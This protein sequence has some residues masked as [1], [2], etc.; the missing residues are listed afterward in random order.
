MTIVAGAAPVFYNVGI[1]P[2]ANIVQTEGTTPPLDE[3]RR[4][5]VGV[6]ITG[7]VGAPPS[8]ADIPVL[9]PIGLAALGLLLAAGAAS[10]IRRRG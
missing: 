9:S 7:T 8:T 10:A 2:C 4:D 5:S 6:A 3:F 1:G